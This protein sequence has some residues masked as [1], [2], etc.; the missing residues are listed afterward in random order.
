MAQLRTRYPPAAPLRRALPGWLV[1]TRLLQA[2][3]GTFGPVT[4]PVPRAR[5][6]MLEGKRVEWKNATKRGEK[7][8]YED[9]GEPEGDKAVVAGKFFLQCDLGPYRLDPLCIPAPHGV[10]GGG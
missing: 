2:E 1:T 6:N 3:M 7:Q 10:R 8:K 9:H 4:V 5:L